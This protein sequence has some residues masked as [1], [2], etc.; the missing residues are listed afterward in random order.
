[1]QPTEGNNML[2]VGQKKK[3]KYWGNYT[4]EKLIILNNPIQCYSTEIGDALFSPVFMKVKWE[5]PPSKDGHEFWFRYWINIHG[6]EKYGQYAPAIGENSLFQ[7][8]KSAIEQ[9][10]FSKDFLT[11]LY[12]VIELRLNQQFNDNK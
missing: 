11:N 10:Y 1:M 5:S 3:A 4:V 12:G 8:L 9:D 7:F 6:K 2:K